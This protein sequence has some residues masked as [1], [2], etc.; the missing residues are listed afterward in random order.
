MRTKDDLIRSGAV[1]VVAVL[2]THG[3]PPAN[4]T[5]TRFEV[6]DN[7]RFVAAHSPP[8][9]AESARIVGTISLAPEPLTK[10]SRTAE[11]P[12]K[13]LDAAAPGIVE[14]ARTLY[15]NGDKEAALKVLSEDN[16]A[17]V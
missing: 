2:A 13:P 3:A 11:Q 10:R 4:A 15:R 9:L 7:G 16:L 8:G 5:S 17:E 6:L 1:I 14:E 12:L